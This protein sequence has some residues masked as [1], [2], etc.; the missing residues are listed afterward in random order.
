VRRRTAFHEVTEHR[1]RGLADRAAAAVET[2]LLD[3]VPCSKTHRN[4]DLVSA[5]RVLTLRERV[6]RLEQPVIS[7]VL[8]V[9]QDQL[10]IQLV[11]LRHGYP[12]LFLAL[13]RPS[14]RRSTSSWME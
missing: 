11:E 2:E 4:G 8:V 3:D 12:R 10:P 7:R 13:S 9:V 1:G 5:K 14:M 6:G